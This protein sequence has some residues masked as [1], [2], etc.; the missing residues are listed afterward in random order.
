LTRLAIDEKSR[1]AS[2]F[3]VQH[4]K[5]ENIYQMAIKHTKWPQNIPNDQHFPLKDNPNFTQSGIF[6]LKIYH[7]ATLQKSLFRQRPSRLV[8]PKQVSISS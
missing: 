1:V 4:T 2:L 8:K 6:G 5:A 3:L 7:L